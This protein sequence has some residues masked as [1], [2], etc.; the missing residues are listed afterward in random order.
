ME[1][2]KNGVNVK[3]SAVYFCVSTE[4][5]DESILESRREGGYNVFP[6]HAACPFMFNQDEMFIT[7]KSAPGTAEF[8]PLS[9]VIFRL[10]YLPWVGGWVGEK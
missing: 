10:F 5:Q 8:E 6:F 1:F 9:W 2:Q 3:Q 7:K 4:Q